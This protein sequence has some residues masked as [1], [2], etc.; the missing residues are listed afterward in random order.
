MRDQGQQYLDNIR[1]PSNQLETNSVTHNEHAQCQWCENEFWMM[2][3][4]S[5]HK[6]IKVCSVC[7]SR[8]IDSETIENHQQRID[9]DMFTMFL[10]FELVIFKRLQVESLIE[11]IFYW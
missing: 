9:L 10:T 5:E 4:Q 6:E 8:S 11:V 1:K 7:C 2:V 3:L